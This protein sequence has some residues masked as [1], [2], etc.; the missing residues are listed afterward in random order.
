MT[1]QPTIC[2]LLTP[3]CLLL[4]LAAASRASADDAPAAAPVAFI[5]G[6]FEDWQPAPAALQQSIDCTQ[7][8]AG[9]NLDQGAKGKN[10]SLARDVDVKHGG[11]AAVRL[12]NTD[13]NAGMTLLQRVDVEPETRYKL[14]L[15]LKGNAI[16]SYHPKG[17]I[18]NVVSSTQTDIK[19]LNV[20]SGNLNAVYKSPSPSSG[21]FDWHQMVFTFDTPIN[22][23]TAMVFIELRGAGTLWLDD[24]SID[25]IEKCLQVES[26]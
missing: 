20:W 13:T 4:C 2:K 7:L 3:L 24:L 9:W 6:G 18:V 21:T 15:W 17:V 23:R 16:D 1:N 10:L 25:R 11:D 26:Y 14:T 12:S 22:T 5:N 8:P 19:D